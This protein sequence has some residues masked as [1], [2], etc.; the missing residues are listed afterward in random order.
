[1]QDFTKAFPDHSVVFFISIIK[2]C[3][4]IFKL[5]SPVFPENL[6]FFQVI[7]HS[8]HI[9]ES[10]LKTSFFF[11]LQDVFQTLFQLQFKQFSSVQ[12]LL[13]FK[14]KPEQDS[15][16]FGQV[17]RTILDHSKNKFSGFLQAVKKQQIKILIIFLVLFHQILCLFKFRLLLCRQ[18]DPGC[19][20]TGKRKRI[21]PQI[22]K[23]FYMS[24]IL[25]A[26]LTKGLGSQFLVNIAEIFLIQKAAASVI[27][28][29]NSLVPVNGV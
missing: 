29:K 8:F 18:H 7:G 28:F 16:S 21:F 6:Q 9:P 20:R 5:F 14:G 24:G 26:G 15:H 25:A 13:Y 3:L 4:E 27:L 12:S 11:S 10:S 19:F 17:Q 22:F 23:F 2:L 1:M